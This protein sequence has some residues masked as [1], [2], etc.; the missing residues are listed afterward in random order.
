MSLPPGPKG[1]PL[2]GSSVPFVRDM[3][4][5][6]LNLAVEFGDLATFYL[7]GRPVVLVNDPVLVHRILVEDA[8]SYIKSQA[9]RRTKIVLGEG[10]LTSEGEFHLRQRRLASRAFP[11]KRVEHYATHMVEMS[12][13]QVSQWQPGQTLDLAAELMELTLRVV[14]K[15]LFDADT[16]DDVK[17]VGQAM[18]EVQRQFPML[19][20]PGTE[21]LSR[22]PSPGARRF[23]RAMRD[24]D[25]VIQR[26][27]EE[28][29]RDPGDRGD[30]LSMLLLH[31]EDGGMT[32]KQLRDEIM[33]IFL[34]GHET[35]ASA[36]ASSFYLLSLHPNVYDQLLEEVDSEL[37][38][39]AATP[40]DYPRLRYTRAVFAEA[41]RLYPPAFTLGREN[42]QTVSLG[43]YVLDPGVTFLLSPYVTQRDPRHFPEP[44]SFDPRRF[45]SEEN[46]PRGAYFPFGGGVRKCLGERYAWMEGVLL[47]AT[48]SQRWRIRYQ[49][50]LPVEYL[51]SVTLRPKHGMRV[52]PEKRR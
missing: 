50:P 40:A 38:E 47:L 20:F 19:L 48:I 6:L 37:G 42:T 15:T 12:R 26:I 14:A 17:K 36:L 10:L 43:D 22:L 21:I 7:L 9:L 2:L 35:T 45:L 46:W 5:F 31:D 18:D 30:L 25:G 34:A 32:R 13:R 28:R 41:M 44:L 52:E 11:G 16:T 29:L 24:L 8:G 27:L 1:W 23:A 51:A 39:R 3:P 49:S 33:T 4:G